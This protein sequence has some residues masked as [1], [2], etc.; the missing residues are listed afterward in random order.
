[1]SVWQLFIMWDAL[2]CGPVGLQLFPLQL[3]LHQVCR[4]VATCTT[5]I[6]QVKMSSSWQQLT[7]S[8]KKQTRAAKESQDQ[9]RQGREPESDQHHSIT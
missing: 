7:R 2:L 5:A 8:P 9:V 1:M 6:D 3:V 4:L